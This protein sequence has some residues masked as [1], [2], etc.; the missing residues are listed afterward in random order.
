[1]RRPDASCMTGL[2]RE[3]TAFAREDC[4]IDVISG[5]HLSHQ[6]AE[7]IVQLLRQRIQFARVVECYD[8]DL[9]SGLELDDFFWRR[10]CVSTSKLV[11]PRFLKGRKKNRLFTV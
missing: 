10:H 7:T 2:R 5:S 8:S 9:A 11:D 1:M 6:T 4:Y 3:E